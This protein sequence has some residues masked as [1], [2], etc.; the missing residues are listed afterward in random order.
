MSTIDVRPVIDTGQEGFVEPD[1][2]TQVDPKTIAP[3]KIGLRVLKGAHYLDDVA[4]GW[5]WRVDPDTIDLTSGDKCVLGQVFGYYRD[6]PDK[7]HGSFWMTRHGFAGGYLEGE[8]SQMIGYRR[9]V[10]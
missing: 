5:Y 4:P 8:W 10:H 1:L 7:K 3:P 9:L 6:T 2:G